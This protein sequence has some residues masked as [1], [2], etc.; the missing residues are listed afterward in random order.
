[1]ALSTKLHETFFL[2]PFC[3][4]LWPFLAAA[5]L[6]LERCAHRGGEGVVGWRHARLSI[7]G[8]LMFAFLG[9]VLLVC[10]EPPILEPGVLRK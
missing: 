5:A 9:K 2:H 3:P 7:L 1:M 6:A 8:G 10:E 4:C